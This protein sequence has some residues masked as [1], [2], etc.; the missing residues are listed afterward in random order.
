VRAK[1]TDTAQPHQRRC[2]IG[3]TVRFFDIAASKG[4][5]NAVLQPGSDRARCDGKQVLCGRRT[6]LVVAALGLVKVAT[7]MTPAMF[8]RC[9][10]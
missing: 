2:D 9:M 4:R 6:P 7:A 1:R 10:P 8:H 5:V 3:T